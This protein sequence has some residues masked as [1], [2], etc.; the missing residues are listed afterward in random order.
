MK[1]DQWINEA[2]YQI[3]NHILLENDHSD[4]AFTSIN[5]A[6]NDFIRKSMLEGYSSDGGMTLDEIKSLFIWVLC[7]H[8]HNC[9]LELLETIEGIHKIKQLLGADDEY[10]NMPEHQGEGEAVYKAFHKIETVLNK[11]HASKI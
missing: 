1:T 8:A 9:T 10:Y 11:Y 6:L 4:L 3:D 2:K 7:R 5:G